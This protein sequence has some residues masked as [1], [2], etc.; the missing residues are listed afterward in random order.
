MSTSKVQKLS[1][2]VY[3]SVDDNTSFSRSQDV[4]HI[5]KT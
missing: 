1:F 3:S 5:S 2:E 4:Y